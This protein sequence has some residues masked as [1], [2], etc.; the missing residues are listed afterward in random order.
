MGNETLKTKAYETIKGRIIDLTYRPGELLKEGCLHDDL[1]LSRTPIRDALSRLESEGFVTIRSKKGILVSP[2][3]TTVLKEVY[4]ARIL[5]E[6][7]ALESGFDFIEEERVREF[8]CVYAKLSVQEGNIRMAFRP[9]DFA[10]HQYIISLSTNRFLTHSCSLL[11]DW[12]RRIGA[13]NTHKGQ[14]RIHTGLDEHIAI[15]NA[16]IQGDRNL[17]VA[18]LKTHLSNAYGYSL[19]NLKDKEKYLNENCEL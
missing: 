13:V 10:L 11:Q 1:G 14:D 8:E 5:L 19:A 15:V 6:C 12:S 16:M 3:S 4:E 2:L 9:W 18:E 7:N 17:A